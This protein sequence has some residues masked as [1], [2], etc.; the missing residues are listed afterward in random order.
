[1]AKPSVIG[2]WIVKKWNE[3][4]GEVKKFYETIKKF[5]ISITGFFKGPNGKISS[6]RVWASI[7]LGVSARQLLKNDR[8]GALVCLIAGV[9]LLALSAA[10]KT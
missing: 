3:F 1:M 2:T 10:T 9:A 8:I 6:K 7:L 5:L 4:W